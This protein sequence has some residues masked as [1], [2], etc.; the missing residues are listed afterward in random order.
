MKK[1]RLQDLYERKLVGPEITGKQLPLERFLQ[2][3]VEFWPEQPKE[4]DFDIVEIGPGTGDFLIHLSKTHKDKKICGIEIGTR[5]FH[6]IQKRLKNH[7]ID[8]A[9]LIHGDARVPFYKMLPENSLE[10]VYVLFPDPWPRTRHC[11]L[12][13]LQEDFLKQIHKCLKKDGELILATDVEDYARWTAKNAEKIKGFKNPYGKETL[14]PPLEEVI[15]TY[16]QK[17]WTEMGRSFWYYK[18]LKT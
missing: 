11:H 5:R 7:L 8:N 1:D 14:A 12:R 2:S 4:L 18:V 9:T 10:K 13:L 16:F 3:K 15:P 6:K 17:K